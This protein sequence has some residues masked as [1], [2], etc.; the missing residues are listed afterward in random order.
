MTVY[1][2]SNLSVPPYKKRVFVASWAENLKFEFSME[3]FLSMLLKR[4]LL[5]QNAYFIVVLAKG[6]FGSNRFSPKNGR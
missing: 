1:P 2:K 6:V 5:V 3:M 4:I